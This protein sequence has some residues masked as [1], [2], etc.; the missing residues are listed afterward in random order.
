VSRRPDESD[1]LASLL[2]A[3]PSPEPSGDFLAGAQRRYRA[4]LAG[5]ARREALTALVATLIGVALIAALLGPVMEPATL[6]AWLAE[7]AADVARWTIGVGIV[8][9]LVPPVVWT[10]MAAGFAA[11]V[12]S[13]VIVAR[14]RS[15]A[16]AK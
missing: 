13:L 1:Q 5:R 6:V 7:A 4:A 10:S 2:R 8:L 3:L 15:L 16:T 11:T 9:A 12:L 14:T